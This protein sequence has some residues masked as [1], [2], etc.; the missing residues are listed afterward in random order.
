M[1][2]N[3]EQGG[4]NHYTAKNYII[5]FIL[6]LVLTLVSFGVVM[7]KDAISKPLLFSVLGIAGVLQLFVQL[8]YFL[9]LDRSK[10]NQWNVIAIGFT[11]I[12]LFVFVAGTIWV[13]Y[14]L[15]TRMM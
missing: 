13:M 3:S 9:H 5:G 2:H 1:S 12:L 14:T 7:M 8:H 4:T 6:A 15:N 11:G 10:E